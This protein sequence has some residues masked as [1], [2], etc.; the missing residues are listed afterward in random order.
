MTLEENAVELLLRSPKL[1]VGTIIDLLD[2][3]D[4]EFRAMASRNSTIANLLEARRSGELEPLASEPVEC[5]ACS[6]WFVPYGSS[7]FCSDIC[8]TTGRIEHEERTK[9]W[10]H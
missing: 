3:G 7:R 2:V 5:P 8:K 9:Q 4:I 1:G 6:E 10:Q